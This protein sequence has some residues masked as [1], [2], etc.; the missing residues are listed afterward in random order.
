[1]NTAVHHFYLTGRVTGGQPLNCMIWKNLIKGSDEGFDSTVWI[2]LRSNLTKLTVTNQEDRHPLPPLYKIYHNFL[3]QTILFILVFCF[4]ILHPI[5]WQY[6]L[7]FYTKTFP[8]I[9]ICF[10]FLEC[11]FLEKLHDHLSTKTG[12]SSMHSFIIPYGYRSLRTDF[13]CNTCNNDPVI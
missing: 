10:C 4:K 8:R 2:T 13:L 7:S 9:M 11:T 3:L 1:M 6:K 5:P 12:I